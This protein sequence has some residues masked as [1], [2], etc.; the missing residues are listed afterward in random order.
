MTSSMIYCN[1][2]NVIWIHRLIISIDC[3]ELSKIGRVMLG[4]EL[5]YGNRSI[6][7]QLSMYIHDAQIRMRYHSAFHKIT[8]DYT[9]YDN[10]KTELV[11]A[12]WSSVLNNYNDKHDLLS[13]WIGDFFLVS[14]LG[15]GQIKSFLTTSMLAKSL[16]RAF[17]NKI[18]RFSQFPLRDD[19]NSQRWKWW[20]ENLLGCIECIGFYYRRNM[21]YYTDVNGRSIYQC[22]LYLSME[23]KISQIRVHKSPS[24]F[25]SLFCQAKYMRQIC[26]CRC[27]STRIGACLPK[28]SVNCY[29]SYWTKI[30]ERQFNLFRLDLFRA[31]VNITLSHFFFGNY[32]M[33]MRAVWGIFEWFRL[34]RIYWNVCRDCN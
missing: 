13:P 16:S 14:R 31:W 12:R 15:Q 5:L 9:A 2:L 28:L 21:F 26:L 24:S 30:I 23:T 3:E 6:C 11:A 17:S 34:F 8:K 33:R 10:R 27:F 1:Y 19:N 25:C 32:F 18:I 22:I 20:W 7:V 29:F 4:K